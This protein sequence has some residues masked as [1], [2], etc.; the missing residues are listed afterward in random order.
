MD[1]S[2]WTAITALRCSTST[3][4]SQFEKAQIG[5]THCKNALVIKKCEALKRQVAHRIRQLELNVEQ[6]AANDLEI[7]RHLVANLQVLKEA[8]GGARL[9][10][11]QGGETCTGRARHKQCQTK[12]TR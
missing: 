1:A 6:P 5:Q 10:L 7:D 12:R 11:Q 8:L 3:H 2:T 4:S 9:D